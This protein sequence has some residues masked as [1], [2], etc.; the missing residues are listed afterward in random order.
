MGT[1]NVCLYLGNL[2][3]NLHTKFILQLRILQSISALLT[4]IT[5]YTKC[6][7]SSSAFV[8]LFECSD[9][10]KLIESAF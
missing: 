10:Q 8:T 9:R 4:L 1:A 5:E 3:V 7:A 2:Q 6:C